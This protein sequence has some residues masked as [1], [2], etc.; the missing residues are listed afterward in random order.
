M[1]ARGLPSVVKEQPVRSMTRSFLEIGRPET[2]DDG[3]HVP[4]GR[5]RPVDL[6]AVEFLLTFCKTTNVT[7]IDTTSNTKLI[8][9]TA[10]H[11]Q[12]PYDT[13]SKA[14]S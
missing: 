11:S 12:W 8:R 14:Y 2:P 3:L 10:Q 6:K 13:S 1:T 9:N 7:G 5:A 4:V